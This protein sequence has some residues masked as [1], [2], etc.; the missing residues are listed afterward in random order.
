MIDY[1]SFGN[2]VR[3]FR[4]RIKTRISCEFVAIKCLSIY[5]HEKAHSVCTFTQLQVFNQTDR[6]KY[7]Q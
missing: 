1:F 5:Y 6:T 4:T 2:L 3:H 7:C